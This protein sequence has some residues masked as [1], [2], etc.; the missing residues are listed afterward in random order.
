MYKS[1]SNDSILVAPFVGIGYS[2][3]YGINYTKAGAEVQNR[4][5]SKKAG[6]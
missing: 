6:K 4:A 5:I 2:K 1:Y 3:S